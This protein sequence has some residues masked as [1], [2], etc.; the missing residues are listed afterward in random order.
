MVHQKSNAVLAKAGV[1]KRGLTS[2]DGP[3]STVSLNV[4]FPDRQ[5]V[6]IT[7]L[8]GAET[9]TC[10]IWANAGCFS[11]EKII[12]ANR[13]YSGTY[14][15]GCSAIPTE[16]SCQTVTIDKAGSIEVDRVSFSRKNEFWYPWLFNRPYWR[17]CPMSRLMSS[18]LLRDGNR[19]PE[20]E[21]FLR[22]V[23]KPVTKIIVM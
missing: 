9:K 7:Q 4:P 19:V 20:F 1:V 6:E 12:L 8:K 17:L 15:R 14:N 11:S 21:T 22:S 2:I 10:P 13:R 3:S 5:A 18:E 16:R 23:K